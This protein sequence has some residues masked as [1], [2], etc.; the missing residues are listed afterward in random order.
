MKATKR[1][2]YFQGSRDPKSLNTLK[3]PVPNRISEFRDQGIRRSNGLS[4][5]DRDR[6]IEG[7]VE[8]IFS[9]FFQAEKP[10]WALGAKKEGA[11]EEEE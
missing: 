4:S 7:V 11:E 9:S 8:P 2:V 6:E 5:S 10:E 1:S 3:N